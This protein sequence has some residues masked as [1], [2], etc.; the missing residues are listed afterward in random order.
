MGPEQVGGLVVSDLN[1]LQLTFLHENAQMIVA[2]CGVGVNFQMLIK[3]DRP[4]RT[5]Y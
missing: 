2:L 3:R 5:L 1:F 4:N